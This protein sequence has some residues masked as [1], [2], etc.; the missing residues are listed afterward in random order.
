M[1]V[2]SGE[3]ESLNDRYVKLE[4]QAAEVQQ[5]MSRD[6][7]ERD[8]LRGVADSLVGERTS[9]QRRLLQIRSE[10]E[11][12]T[13]DAEALEQELQQTRA[14]QSTRLGALDKVLR[15]YQSVLGLELVPGDD[16]LH[17]V[18]TLVDPRDPAR[19][20]AF[21]VKVLED[22]TY[23]VTSCEPQL[24][25][26]GELSQ[27]L[28]QENRFADFVKAARRGFSGLVQ[29]EIEEEEEAEEAQ[30]AARRPA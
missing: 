3:V 12:E 15:L 6:C 2:A 26:L 5:F 20:F 10:L 9:L 13:K 18:F 27:L 11:S 17:L 30:A 28:R 14:E 23:M 1:R 19:R 22:N 25:S 29:R 21:G 7:A 4:R 24:E 16:E 8:T